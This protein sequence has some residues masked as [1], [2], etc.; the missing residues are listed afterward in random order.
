MCLKGDFG[1]KGGWEER[2]LNFFGIKGN[3]IHTAHNL[4]Q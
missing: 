1:G 2:K 3:F 4:N